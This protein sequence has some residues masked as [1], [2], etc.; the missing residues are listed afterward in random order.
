MPGNT[1]AIDFAIL[2]V[3]WDSHCAM[4]AICSHWTITKDQL[5]RLKA[6]VPLQPRH[7]RRFRF[8]PPRSE[9]RDP[10]PLEIAE[11]CL[12]IQAGWDTRTR[13]QRSSVKSQP[14][15]LKRIEMTDEARELLEGFD[16]E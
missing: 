4:A 3:Q 10:T 6:V 14:F 16:D 9:Y 11:A 13:E 8:K 7:D 5:I 12:R 1:A 15:T 2:Q